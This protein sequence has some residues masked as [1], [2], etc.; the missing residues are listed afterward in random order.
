MF[1]MELAF[2]YLVPYIFC[3]LI[4]Y[5]IDSLQY[6]TQSCLTHCGPMGGSPPGSFVHGIFHA[7]I[8]EW[9]AISYSRGSSQPKDQ[10]CI[11]F[12]SCI[13]RQIFFYN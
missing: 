12:N 7:K 11:S 5:Q 2:S 4:L 6:I 3:I 13:G 8:L 10:N 9:V 1:S